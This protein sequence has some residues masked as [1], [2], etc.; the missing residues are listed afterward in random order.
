VMFADPE[1]VD[2]DLVGEHALLDEVPDRLSV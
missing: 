2:S 1:E